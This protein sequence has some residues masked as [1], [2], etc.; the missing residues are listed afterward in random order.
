MVTNVS[1]SHSPQSRTFDIGDSYMKLAL[2][3]LLEVTKVQDGGTCK[4]T[5]ATNKTFC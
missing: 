4:K 3:R 5:I 2:L 1:Q